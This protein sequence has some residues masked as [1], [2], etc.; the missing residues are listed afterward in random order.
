MSRP[1]LTFL[2]PSLIITVPY[3]PVML[4]LYWYT[5]VRRKLTSDQQVIRTKDL[6]FFF[7]RALGEQWKLGPHLLMSLLPSSVMGIG[8]WLA[9]ISLVTLLWDDASAVLPN[10]SVDALVKYIRPTFFGFLGAYFFMLQTTLRRYLDDDLGIDTHL[11]IAVRMLSALIVSFIGGFVLPAEYEGAINISLAVF[12]YGASFIFGVMPERGFDTLYRIVSGW[13]GERF[14]GQ[15]AQHDDLQACLNLD[16]VRT[17][18]LNVENVQTIDDLA[19]AEIE[20]LAQ[21]TRFDL[22]TIFYWVDRAIFYSQFK[23]SPTGQTLETCGVHTFSAFEQ[24]YRDTEARA[25]IETQLAQPQS[26]DDE[27]SMGLDVAYTAMLQVPNAHLV[28]LFTRYKASQAVGAFEATNRAAA[29]ARM[30]R[31]EEA[32]AEYSDALERNPLDPTLLTRR[33]AAWSQLAQQRMRDKDFV[34]GRDAFE[35]ALHDLQR[36]LDILPTSWEACLTRARV[37]L[38]QKPYLFDR[39]VIAE[40]L[41]QAEQDLLSAIKHNDEELTLINAL[42]QVYIEQGEYRKARTL[43]EKAL[44]AKRY[45]SPP[46]VRTT[47]ELIAARALIAQAQA[48]DDGVRERLLQRAHGHISQAQAQMPRSA[49][50]FA[51]QALYHHVANPGSKQEERFLELALDPGQVPILDADPADPA[52]RIHLSVDATDDLYDM[53]GDLC[54]QRGDHATALA[55]YT[56]T[57]SVNPSRTETYIKRGRLYERLGDPHASLADYSMLIG[58]LEYESADVYLARARAESLLGRHE[59]EMTIQALRDIERA[60][61]LAPDHPRPLIDWGDWLR[62][63]GQWEQALEAYERAEEQL[64]KTT[65]LKPAWIDLNVGRGLAYSGLGDRRRA[66]QAL[67]AADKAAGGAHGRPPELWIGWGVLHSLDAADPDARMNAYDAFVHLAQGGRLAQEDS[68]STVDAADLKQMNESLQTM[69]AQMS[70]QSIDRVSRVRLDLVRARVAALMGEPSPHI[71]AAI[72][73]VQSEIAALDDETQRREMEA[74]FS[75]CGELQRL[76]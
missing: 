11:I 62:L 67:A 29:L 35:R 48:H 22:Q 57:L 49:M 51:T 3:L 50:L 10:L 69:A 27:K 16:R 55:C 1:F 52:F 2:I 70:A 24:I 75:R 33:G 32:V 14:R 18:R 5:H 12:V 17:A 28:R 4:L 68:L 6:S 59:E 76:V 20:R 56:Q 40:R 23:D 38:G 54:A 26:A 9:S 66:H 37:L 63:A 25:H 74:L 60:I 8:A 64:E 73:T 44:D 21:K 13:L 45:Q 31:H 43:I 36:A 30:D 71:A 7:M 61:A 46:H 19:H 72:Q 34:G 15:N 39:A 41:A 53:W 42:G 47:A 65:E 58:D